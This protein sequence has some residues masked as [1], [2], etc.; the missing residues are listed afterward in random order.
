[1]TLT[2]STPLSDVILP[3]VLWGELTSE[4][5]TAAANRDAFVVLP[6]G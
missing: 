2:S 3:S 5:L 1:M 6:L 4:E